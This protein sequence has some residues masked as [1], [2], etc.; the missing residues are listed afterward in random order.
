MN[1]R[2][3]ALLALEANA[4]QNPDEKIHAGP[5][6]MTYKEAIEKIKEGNTLA[7]K[8][9]LEPLMKNLK[10]KSFRAKVIQTLGLERT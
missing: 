10:S 9:V 6:V 2:E 4:K 1:N 5:L 8:L 7:I 3:L